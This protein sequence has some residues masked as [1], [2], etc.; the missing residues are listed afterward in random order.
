MKT[1]LSLLLS[2]SLCTTQAVNADTNLSGN[3]NG[4]ELSA[5]T[6]VFVVLGTFEAVAKAGKV[7]VKSVEK[8]GDS[9]VVVVEGAA[10]ASR[11]TLRF[12]GAALGTASLVAG[13]TLSVVTVASGYA[14]IAAGQVIAFFPNEAGKALM[15]QS[16]YQAGGR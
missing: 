10:Q 1:L 16:R 3:L 7:V 4:S 15:H 13:T 2:C 14:L 6:S 12:S 5:L 9:V 8:A 11:T